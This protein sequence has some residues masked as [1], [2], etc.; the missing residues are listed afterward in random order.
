MRNGQLGT[1]YI[2]EQV[3]FEEGSVG[4]AMYIIQSGTVRI[5]KKTASGEVDIATLQSGEI[6][7]EMALF[8][9]LP[10]SATV[11]ASG[12][13]RLLSVDREKF[14]SLV[15]KDPTLVFRMLE[16]MS[17]RLRSINEELAELKKHG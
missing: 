5:T 13:V 1:V 16:T 3:I 6:F 11:I 15:S 2:D 7:G 8:D 17:R 10:R 9:H 14:I 4:D 12:E